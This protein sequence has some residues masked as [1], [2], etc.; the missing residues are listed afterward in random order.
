MAQIYLTYTS[1][2]IDKWCLK[3]I[4]FH[5]T[6]HIYLYTP[7]YLS[8]QFRLFFTLTCYYGKKQ[9]SPV[10][11]FNF[12]S[13]CSIPL[14]KSCFMTVYLKDKQKANR[15]AKPISSKSEVN[16]IYFCATLSEPLLMLFTSFTPLII[17]HRRLSKPRCY[18]MRFPPSTR[19][20][21]AQWAAGDARKQNATS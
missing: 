20:L 7:I 13:I 16:G 18:Q 15:S 9:K 12:L 2:N 4:S 6:A 17:L 10:Q 3:P 1:I 11:F 14:W 8:W 5:R 21:C 19:A